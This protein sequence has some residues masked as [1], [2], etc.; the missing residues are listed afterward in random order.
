MGTQLN[1]VKEEEMF[2]PQATWHQP[3]LQNTKAN[4]EM[5]FMN[6]C[7]LLY[8]FALWPQFEG[9]EMSFALVA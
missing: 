8:T 5:D 6:S 4:P 9:Q 1:C 2:L 3:V 7:C